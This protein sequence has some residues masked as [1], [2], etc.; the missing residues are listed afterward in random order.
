MSSRSSATLATDRGCGKT[1]TPRTLIA[2]DE[3][4][5]VKGHGLLVLRD[6]DAVLFGC[7]RQDF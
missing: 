6:K 7:E 5:K 4:R 1:D 3:R 2:F